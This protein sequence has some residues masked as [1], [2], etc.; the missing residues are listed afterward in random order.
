MSTLRSL[1]SRDRLI[2]WLLVIAAVLRVAALAEKG[3]GYDGNF[4]DVIEFMKSAQ[5]LVQ[6]GQYTFYQNGLSALA[7]PGFV[8]MLVPFVAFG[9]PVYGQLLALKLVLI[10]ISLASIYVLSLLGRR[11]GGTWVGLAAAAMLTV[12]MPHI[13]VGSLALSE[14]PYI[15]GLLLTTLFTI[16]LADKPGW[17]PF[18]VVLACFVATLY[19]RQA[20]T[21]LLLAAF[22][23]LLVRKY[24]RPL[25][26]KQVATAVVITAL[27]LSP[28]WV[29]NYRAFGA[30]VPFTSLEGAPLFEGT[31]QRFQ[32]YGNGALDDMGRIMEGFTGS[33]LERSR[34][35]A[36]AAR[37][38]LSI[39]LA[40]NPSDVLVRYVVMKPAA[41][42][43][44]P[45]Y[46]DSFFAIS[47]YWV[48]RIHA[49]AS[50]AGLLALAWLSVR[51]QNRAEFLLLLV[52]VLVITVGT[53]YYLGLSRYVFP[54]M[55]FLYIG[56][57]YAAQS[58]ARAA[59]FRCAEAPET[60]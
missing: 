30:F 23:Y 47:G 3:A 29:R 13:Y 20:A 39:Q 45:F 18:F 44:L 42:W 14:N 50:A 7:M 17:R 11:I 26:F 55:P 43:L 33:E 37:E 52:N 25:L 24:P 34:V 10:V 21:G 53:G 54:Y 60:A 36:A 56:L 19:L 38:R 57:A 8:L 32:P 2:W 41:A 9:G 35:L 49:F 16:R 51:S 46:W 27:A 59:F 1:F 40:T 48:L 28:W 58:L 15:L 12:S 31:Y 5:N 4:N 6:T 22:V